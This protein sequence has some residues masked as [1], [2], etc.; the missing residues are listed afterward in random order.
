MNQI[1][2]TVAWH[3]NAL[4][5]EPWYE[6][7]FSSLEEAKAFAHSLDKDEFVYDVTDEF[8]NQYDIDTPEEER[9]ARMH[10]FQKTMKV[11]PVCR[12]Y[13]QFDIGLWSYD[14]RHRVL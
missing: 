14:L 3:T 4:N 8:G 5:S 7:E 6:K 10:L 2:Y 9:L 11:C 1:I 12:H 13:Y